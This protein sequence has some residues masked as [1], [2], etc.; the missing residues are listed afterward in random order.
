MAGVIVAGVGLIPLSKPGPGPS[1][2]RM[3]AAAG[4]LVLADASVSDDDVQPSCAGYAC[5]ESAAGQRAICRPGM[6]GIPIINVNNNC[7][8]GS[9]ALHFA[10]QAIGS[11]EVDWVLARGFEQRRREALGSLF[12]DRPV[13]F[14]PFD[15]AAERRVDAKDEPLALRYFGGAGLKHRNRR[16]EHRPNA[17]GT[18]CGTISGSAAQAS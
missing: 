17:Q 3:G 6:T 14:E 1:Y 12:E 2:G 16:E 15:E 18:R 11:C 8:T 4:R 7:A 9:T 5:G 13:P 10:R